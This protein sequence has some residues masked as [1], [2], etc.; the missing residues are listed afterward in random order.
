VAI[1][2]TSYDLS[3]HGPNGFLRSFKGSVAGHRPSQLDVRAS[4]DEGRSTLILTVSNN[5]LKPATVNV[6]CGYTGQHVQ[7]LLGAGESTSQR[8]L[9][10]RQRGWYDLRVTIEADPSFEVR[11]AGHMEDGEAS[12][13]DPAMGRVTLPS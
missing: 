7:A 6:D 12:I 9:L 4:Y 2:A 1:G 11:F 8:W 13:S 5:G 10:Q 3:V